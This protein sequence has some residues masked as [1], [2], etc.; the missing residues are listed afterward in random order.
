VRIRSEFSLNRS[1]QSALLSQDPPQANYTDVM[2]RHHNFEAA[3][4]DLK[5]VVLLDGGTY[6]T[7]ADLFNNSNAMIGIDDLVT[8][9]EIAIAHHREAP[10]SA[11]RKKSK[12][13]IF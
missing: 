11:G 10:T 8:Y 1:F 13:V 4:L 12:T 5:E 3:G 6:G 9:V 7:T 2:E